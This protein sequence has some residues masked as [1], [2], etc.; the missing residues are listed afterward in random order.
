MQTLLGRA[1]AASMIAFIVLF[2]VATFAVSQLTPQVTRIL[3]GR[4]S[5]ADML[6]ATGYLAVLLVSI[7][8]LGRIIYANELAAGRVKRRVKLFE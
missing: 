2:F 3:Q 6:V 5:P 4:M 7:V 8:V 1:G